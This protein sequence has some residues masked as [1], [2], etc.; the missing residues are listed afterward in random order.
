M[1][2]SKKQERFIEKARKIHGDKYDYSKVEYV[3]CN[4]PVCIVYPGYGEFWMTPSLHLQTK[5]GCTRELLEKVTFIENSKLKYNNKFDYSKV[6]YINADTPV[7]ILCPEHGEFWQSPTNHLYLSKYGCKECGKNISREKTKQQRKYTTETFIA[8]CKEKFPNIFTYDKTKYVTMLTPVIITK[9]NEDIF[10][11]PYRLFHSEQVYTITE[12]KE[13]QRLEIQNKLIQKAI[14][15]FGNEYDYSKVRYVN[16]NT[17]VTIISKTHGEFQQ[18]LQNHINSNT[19]YPLANQQKIYTFEF[20]EKIAR[21]YKTL[22]DFR[23]N[24]NLVYQRSKNNN[25]LQTFTWFE[26]DINTANKLVNVYKKSCVYVYKLPNKVAYVGLTNDIQRRHHEHLTQPK[27]SILQYSKKL[28]IP[29]P[30]PEILINNITKKQSALEEKKYIQKF[31]TDGWLLLNKNDGGSLGGT[32]KKWSEQFLID[33]CKHFTSPKDVEKVN[34]ALYKYVYHNKLQD[35]C[36]P[37][38]EIK[39]IERIN[40]T[41]ELVDKLVAQYENKTELRKNN[42]ALFTYLFR[43]GLLFDYFP[44]TNSK[45]CRNTTE[46]DKQILQLKEDGKTP[47]EIAAILGDVSRYTVENVIRRNNK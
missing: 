44:Y 40:Y 14:D 38:S 18:T 28:N 17:P 45:L 10:I 34:Y 12:Q 1:E 9:N 39:P 16:Q 25:Y 35:K 41:P 8:T 27:D 33:F 21:Q 15:K 31:K 5:H 3:D 47:R 7:C 42:K 20:C 22:H 26:N 29:I 37:G 24:D 30:E 43:H 36:F 4:T 2:Q 6:N 32:T 23:Q 11:T 13:K 46:R 19:G